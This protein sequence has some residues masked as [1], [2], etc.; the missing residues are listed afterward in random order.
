M[1]CSKM[2][3]WTQILDT[4]TSKNLGISGVIKSVFL[5]AD[6]MTGGW[7]TLDNFKLGVSRQKDQDLIRKLNCYPHLQPLGKEWENEIE[8]ITHGNDLINRS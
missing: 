2:W 7:R 5:Y 4:R 1:I 6:Q 3:S 8:L